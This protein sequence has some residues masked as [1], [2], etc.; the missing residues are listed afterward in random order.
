MTVASVGVGVAAGGVA[1]VDGVGDGITV[2][3]AVGVAVDRG[4]GVGLALLPGTIDEAPF[5]AATPA[6]TSAPTTS[7]AAA[8]IHQMR[9]RLVGATFAPGLV[10]SSWGWC[11]D[12]A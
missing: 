7:A 6:M 11:T 3:V 10:L 8:P 12:I 2:G 1:V 9:R 4:L 5:D